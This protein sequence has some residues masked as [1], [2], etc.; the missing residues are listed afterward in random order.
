M[1]TYSGNIKIECDENCGN[2]PKK[3]LLKEF[4]IAFVKNET[5]FC[6]DYM[7]DDVIWNIVGKELIRG[8]DDF[9]N[10]LIQMKNREVQQICIQNI[11][12]HGNTGSVNGTLLLT[13]KEKIAFCDVYNFNGFGKNSKI[14]EIT[15][16][17]IKTV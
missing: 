1:N 17:V 9:E 4:S 3:R 6:I 15:S 16:Y 14:K 11:I 7:T 8:K 5:D 12:T 10:A 13:N 2:S